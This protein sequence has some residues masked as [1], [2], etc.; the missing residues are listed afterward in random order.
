MRIR[1]LT[2]PR[3]CA[4]IAWEAPPPPREVEP[5]RADPRVGA[6]AAGGGGP[7]APV[8]E[9]EREAVLAG[10]PGQALL[11]DVQRPLARQEAGV[12]ARVRVAEHHRLAVAVSAQRVAVRRA[13]VERAHR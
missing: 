9:L 1:P 2:V 7:A 4:R 10:L 12:L 5:P 13:G 6:P 11:G 3:G 8:E